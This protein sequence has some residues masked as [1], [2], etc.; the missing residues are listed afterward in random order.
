MTGEPKPNDPG[1]ILHDAKDWTVRPMTAR[2]IERTRKYLE[3]LDAWRKANPGKECP[4]TV[5]YV[6]KG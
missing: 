6:F 3:Q 5:T 1:F 2:E 4:P